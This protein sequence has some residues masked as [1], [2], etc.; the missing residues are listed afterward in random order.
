MPRAYLDC[1]KNRT[2]IQVFAT[3]QLPPHL[4]Q[5]LSKT[6]REE[7]LSFT[8]H[9]IPGAAEYICLGGCFTYHFPTRTMYIFMHTLE[10]STNSKLLSLLTQGAASCTALLIPSLIVQLNL[11][12]RP[13][14]LDAWHDRMLSL[15]RLL[16]IRLDAAE[17]HGDDLTTIDYA[18]VSRDINNTMTNIGYIIWLCRTTERLM[19]FLDEVVKRYRVQALANGVSKEEV[20]DVEFLLKESHQHLRSWNKGIEDRA[21]Y[22]S[23]RGTTLTQT[24]STTC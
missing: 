6:I 23:R 20:D 19:E 16:K 5:V 10:S 22:L 18:R 8:T 4:S 12:N 13:S 2:A 21:E 9:S 11:K 3:P 17:L 7:Y 14:A 24:V 15:E 1:L